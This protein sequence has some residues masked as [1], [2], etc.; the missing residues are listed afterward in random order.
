MSFDPGCILLSLI[1][2]I[3]TVK[4]LVPDIEGVPVSLIT[5]G[6]KYSFCCSLLNESKEETM[7]IPSPFAPSETKEKKPAVGYRSELYIRPAKRPTTTPRVGDTIVVR[8]HTTHCY[9]SQL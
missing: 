9:R 2:P 4:V 6:I 5:I 8:V 7:A 1:S 3:I